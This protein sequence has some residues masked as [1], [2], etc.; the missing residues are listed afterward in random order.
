MGS[1]A[2]VAA[3]R[4]VFAV[5]VDKDNPE[6][7]LVA[8]I[9][10]NLARIPPTLA[11]SID[12][13]GKLTWEDAPVSGVDAESALSSGPPEEAAERRD[14]EDFL[15]ESL[16]NGAMAA[17]EIKNAAREN[18]IA[19]RT[20]SRAKSRLGVTVERSGFGEGSRWYWLLPPKVVTST[21]KVATHGDVAT[22]AQPIDT[23]TV[24]SM[25]LPKIATS[26]GVATFE[27]DGG[28]LRTARGEERL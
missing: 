6:R 16:A 13:T 9:K 18:G 10:N 17:K 11:Y 24:T 25:T 28:N 8:G 4:S 20:L 21:P 27:G 7:R 1:I 12:D 2:F 19:D 5:A 14:A 15:R 22:F 26:E 3:A 23:N